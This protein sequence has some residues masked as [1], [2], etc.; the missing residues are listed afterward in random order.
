[1]GAPKAS[2]PKPQTSNAE[3]RRGGGGCSHFSQGHGKQV[4]IFHMSMCVRHDLLSLKQLRYCC[5]FR[6]Q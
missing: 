6:V 2:D 3:K 5:K 4:N 1:M